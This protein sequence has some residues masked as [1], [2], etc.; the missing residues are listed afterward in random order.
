MGNSKPVL[1]PF[2]ILLGFALGV[3]AAP[4]IYWG[5]RTFVLIAAVVMFLSVVTALSGKRRG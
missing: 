5:W 2:L 1:W 4:Y 3:I